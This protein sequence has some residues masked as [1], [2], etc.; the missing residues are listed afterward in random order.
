MSQAKHGDNVKVHYKGTLDDGTIF[1]TSEGR[2]PLEF[3]IGDGNI[4]PGF[5]EAVIGMSPGDSKSQPIPS[6]QAY[7]PMIPELLA[8]VERDQIPS[9]ITPEVGQQLQIKQDDGQVTIVTI[10]EVNEKTVSLDANH[11]LAGKDLTFEITLV[12]VV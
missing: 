4:I 2:D 9:H 8:E 6:D 5:E 7:G 3:T 1:D 12:E 11:P 10:T